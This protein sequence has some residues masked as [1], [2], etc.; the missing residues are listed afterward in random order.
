MKSYLVMTIAASCAIAAT[1]FPTQESQAQ[2]IRISGSVNAGSGGGSIV[3]GDPTPTY[4]YPG[5]GP[6]TLIPDPYG[7][8]YP[9]FWG[10]WSNPRHQPTTV[11]VGPI[12]QPRQVIIAPNQGFRSWDSSNC[13]TLVYGSPIPSPYLANPITG[14]RCR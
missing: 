4:F 6:S 7:F 8:S 11:I 13:S 14:T 1:L 5:S 10:G 2:S 3:V 12:I 9:S